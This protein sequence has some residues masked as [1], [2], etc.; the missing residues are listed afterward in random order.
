MNPLNWFR[1]I[2]AELAEARE[3]NRQIRLRR[4]LRKRRVVIMEP[5][6]ADER[7]SIA[8]HEAIV[9]RRHA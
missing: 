2:N 4:A 5:P 6:K 3:R 1:R 7:S 8:M 9:N